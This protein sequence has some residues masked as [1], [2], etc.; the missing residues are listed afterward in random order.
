MQDR[1]THVCGH[2][3]EVVFDSDIFCTHCGSEFSDMHDKTLHRYLGISGKKFSSTTEDELERMFKEEEIKASC[4]AFVEGV[5]LID[6][7]PKDVEDII[8]LLKKQGWDVSDSSK[9]GIT[10]MGTKFVCGQC[11]G[12]VSDSASFCTHCGGELEPVHDSVKF[13]AKLE[14]VDMMFLYTGTHKAVLALLKGSDKKGG[15]VINAQS[16]AVQSAWKKVSAELEP[17]TKSE[18]LVGSQAIE[19]WGAITSKHFNPSELPFIAEVV[20]KYKLAS[21][22]GDFGAWLKRWTPTKMK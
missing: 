14:E 15:G 21:K 5:L 20:N 22:Q 1:V 17:L 6:V 11:R 16:A 10:E 13:P 8:K 4:V 3:R 12:S 19:K 9:E 7:D 2:C 18:D